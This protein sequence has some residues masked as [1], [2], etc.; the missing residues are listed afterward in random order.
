[1]WRMTKIYTDIL[2]WKDI[3]GAGLCKLL[4]L[5]ALANETLHGYALIRRIG[6]QT[7]EFCHPSEGTVYPILREFT[8]NG[9]VSVRVNTVHGRERKEYTLTS[10]GREALQTGNAV[11]RRGI[12]CLQ[13]Q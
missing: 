1:M 2:Y 4:I 7:G 11:W 12:K 3:V 8:R 13:D 5:R 9:Y 10:K 6:E